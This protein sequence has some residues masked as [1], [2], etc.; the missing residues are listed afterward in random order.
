MLKAKIMEVVGGTS[1]EPLVLPQSIEWQQISVNPSDSQFIDLLRFEVEQTCRRHG[2]PPSMVYA[3]VSGQNVTYANVSQ[4]DLHYLKHTL[5]YPIDLVEDALTDLVSRPK[6]VRLNRDA[7][8]RADTAGR[9]VAYE[10]AL[11][12]RFAT[13]NEVRTLEDMEPFGSDFD[14]PGIP[15]MVEPADDD[16]DEEMTPA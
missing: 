11:R 9:Y 5:S 6:I 4:A 7:I 2:V 10:T 3:A 1:R 8:L 16:S 12:N 13:V 15:P 14:E